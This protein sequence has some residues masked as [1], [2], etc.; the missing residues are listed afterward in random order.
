MPQPVFFASAPRHLGS[1]LAE[2][3]AGLSL[4]QVAETRG[5]ARFSGR[6]E[7]AYR[8]CL[9]SR[10][11]NRILLPI[12]RFPIDG[13]DDLYAGAADIAWED[14]LSPERTFAVHLDGAVPGVNRGQF[15]VLRVKDAIAD[16]FTRRL[17]HR[18]NVDVQTP[19]L[20]IHVYVRQGQALV[21]IDLSGTSLHRRGYRHEGTAAPLKE[22]LAAA[23]LLRAGW[24]EIAAEGG[25]L[26]D[27]MCGS[28]TLV[29]EGALIAADIAPGLL[30]Q[31]FGFM[32]WLGHDAAAWRGLLEEADD[33]RM[34][35]LQRLGSLRGYDRDSRVIRIALN[36]LGRAGLAGRVHFERRE[37]AECRPGRTD[38]RGLVVVNPPYGERLDAEG[39]LPALYARLGSVLQ[40]RFAGWRAALFTGN[41]D[42]GKHLGLRAHRIHRL[43]NGPI[44]SVLLHFHVDPSAFVRHRP[45]AAS[46]AE[47]SAGATMLANRLSKNLKAL[48]QWRQ[49]QQIECFRLYDADLPEYAL[50]VDVYEG[51]RQWV[52]IQEY[53]APASVDPKRARQ[54]LREAL[55]VIPEVLGIPDTRMF[56]KVRR[57]QKGSAQYE[58]LAETRRFHEVGER[59]LRFLVNFE[60][61]L[62]TGLF[63]DHRDVRRMIGGLAA[64]LR[65]LNLFA[66]TGT[67]TVYAAKGD[68]AATTTVDMSRTYLDWA[69]N[70]LAVNRIPMQ[71]QELIQADC[72]EWLHQSVDKRCFDLILLD[73]PSF[74]ASKRMQGTLDIQRDHVELIR[75]TIRLLAPGGLLIFSNNLRRFRM[76]LAALE[77][78]EVLDISAETLPRDFARNPRIHS[79]WK[80]RRRG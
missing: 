78:L 55:G 67:A 38:D 50:A 80:I 68:A 41:P 53:A 15:A 64:G 2:E 63:L 49:A 17:G 12:A 21:S 51:D 34:A 19:D 74:S 46:L 14:H 72:L 20:R 5:G 69:R 39:G 18:P 60:D 61:Y 26:L 16:R 37:L 33:R 8:A 24:P 7:D 54:R 43:Y 65:F 25:A 11:A 44:P 66:Y 32:G 3:L 4:S 56:F 71:R 10:V 59:G 1:L 57:P 30:R 48:K 27:P 58:R 9:W 6:L 36:H 73:P 40:E 62:D 13:P 52:H 42:L 31:R 35:G 47:R 70:N 77:D 29:I 76:D 45:R 79:C 22:N 75:N 23:L 28:G